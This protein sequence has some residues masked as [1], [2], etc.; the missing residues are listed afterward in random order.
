MLYKSLP[1]SKP[2]RFPWQYNLVLRSSQHNT[3]CFDFLPFC[4]STQL[5]ACLPA[6]VIRAECINLVFIYS[7]WILRRGLQVRNSS[8]FWQCTLSLLALSVKS[9]DF[10]MT[11][12]LFS[13]ESFPG[14]DSNLC[15]RIG[16]SAAL[17]PCLRLPCSS[18]KGLGKA[19]KNAEGHGK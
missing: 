3:S 16:G 13:W 18:L 19:C 17:D 7:L 5:K 14:G 8:S 12:L 4:L 6:W 10:F 9:G 11:S 15:L 2:N 1:R